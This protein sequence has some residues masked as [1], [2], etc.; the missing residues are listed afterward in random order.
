MQKEDLDNQDIEAVGSP[1]QVTPAGL[2]NGAVMK[3]QAFKIT[4]AAT[5][6]AAASS[7]TVPACAWSDSSTVGFVIVAD[8]LTALAGST[9][10]GSAAETTAKVRIDARVEIG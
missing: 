4:K 7:L 5:A 2:D 8:P 1:Q 9:D 10:L 3:C 6:T